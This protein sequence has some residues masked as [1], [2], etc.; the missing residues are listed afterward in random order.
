MKASTT[1]TTKEDSFIE[2]PDGDRLSYRLRRPLEAP[3]GGLVTVLEVSPYRCTDLTAIRDAENHGFFAGRGYAGLRVDFRGS[4]NSSGSMSGML[5]REEQD[6]IREAAEWIRRQ[7]WSNGKIALLGISWGGASSLL[8]LSRF[9]NLFAGAI[10]ISYYHDAFDHGLNFIGGCLT[11]EMS[12]WNG[13]V[14]SYHC[15]PPD[16]LFVGDHWREIWD[17]R[18]RSLVPEQ[19]NTLQH[20]YRD[21]YWLDRS[22]PLSEIPGCPVL[23]MSGLCDRNF[24]DS[25]VRTVSSFSGRATAVI[26]PWAHRW[27]HLAVPGPTVDTHRLVAD[28]LDVEVSGQDDSN[29]DG[30]GEVTLW[31]ECNRPALGY[32]ERSNGAWTRVHKERLYDGADNRIRLGLHPGALK[33]G[34]LGSGKIEL[35]E[36]RRLSGIDPGEIMPAF[37]AGPEL[38]LPAD[39]RGE[40]AH[41]AC[42]DTIPF[43]IP[44]TIVGIPQVMLDVRVN[45]AVAHV[46]CQ[47]SEI[48]SSGEVVRVGLG[49]QNLCFA[50]PR[51]PA[52]LRS[53]ADYACEIPLGFVSYKLAEGSRLRLSISTM[54]WPIIWPPPVPVG[55]TVVLDHSWLELPV[56]DESSLV[57]VSFEYEGATSSHCDIVRAERAPP[58][59]SRKF[60]TWSDGRHGELAIR[61]NFGRYVLKDSSLEVESALSEHY[62]IDATRPS[63]A[64]AST[65]WHWIFE[66]DGWQCGVD[67]V[68]ETRANL[69]AFETRTSIVRNC[70]GSLEPPLEFRRSFPRQFG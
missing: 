19:Y 63:D 69:D 18:V 45:K 7:Q 37:N 48:K 35:D 15:R 38:E 56:A 13:A 11:N 22:V 61:N 57:P 47:L 24:T 55:L 33:P 70:N 17:S 6:D 41:A 4:G 65:A 62:H 54:C 32:F 9:P 36:P 28:W 39:F 30:L 26:G 46:V 44:V 51:E 29:F 25:L 21:Q 16:P 31:V 2:L 5:G 10:L 58:R 52:L 23:L 8:A 20:P 60:N 3:I 64:R 43:E 59:H 68:T 42:F 53:G 12:G 40:A 67:V 49:A 14:T 50:T 27:P 66:R 1:A 34:R